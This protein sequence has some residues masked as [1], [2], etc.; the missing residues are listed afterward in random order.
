MK[1]VHF[2]AGN[3]GRGFVGLLMHRSGYEVVFADV[4]APLIDALASTPSYTVHEVGAGSRD[5]VV[6]GYRALNSADAP[7]SVVAEIA[8]ADVVTTAVGAHILKFVA[9][10]VA[11]GIAARPDEYVIANASEYSSLQF[12]ND[13]DPEQAVQRLHEQPDAF[14]LFEHATGVAALGQTIGQRRVEALQQ[15]GRLQE[16]E[17]RR[18]ERD[19]VLGVR[20]DEG[21]P[22]E[23]RGD[24]LCDKGDP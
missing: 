10:L 18:T 13:A 21:G 16:V 24:H 15:A 12:R 22:V 17:G 9:P 3:I 14:E 19:G 8:T 6:E 1:C 5:T 11:R 20:V 23:R 7:E 2:G 4:A